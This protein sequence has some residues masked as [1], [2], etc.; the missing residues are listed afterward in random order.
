M[1]GLGAA[2]GISLAAHVA[3]AA[4]AY[5]GWPGAVHTDQSA[6][7]YAELVYENP[8]D[9]SFR[10][11]TT[12]IIPLPE[13]TP[14]SVPPSPNAVAAVSPSEGA[15]ATQT[16]AGPDIF[17]ET[18]RPE[19]LAAEPPTTVVSALPG[20]AAAPRQFRA[21]PKHK[22]PVPARQSVVPMA[23]TDRGVEMETPSKMLPRL[24]PALDPTTPPGIARDAQT[25]VERAQKV[26]ALPDRTTTS[27]AGNHTSAPQYAA[28]ALGNEPPKYPL[29]ARR[30]GMAGRVVIEAVVDRSGRIATAAVAVSSGHRLLDRT[31]LRAVRNW[32]FQP[33]T[34]GGRAVGATISI[35]ITFKLET[36]TV[37][38]QE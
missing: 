37:V 4:G 27:P 33:A 14:G 24:A 13:D 18:A 12:R 2:L 34:R 23:A 36:T 29:A 31:A 7:I 5:V 6:P 25:E 8:A 1:R 35:P 20:V 30:R 38:A 22:P 21:R 15:A 10:R 11:E 28:P 17:V 32:A 3:V 16:S 26:V 9:V 19:R